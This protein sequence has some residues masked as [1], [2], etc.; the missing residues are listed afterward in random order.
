MRLFRTQYLRIIALALGA[1]FL[2]ACEETD[3]AVDGLDDY[4]P[5]E[6]GIEWTYTQSLVQAGVELIQAEELHWR[7]DGDTVIDNKSYTRI[8]DVTSGF[9]KKVVRKEGTKYYGRNHEMYGG[10]THEYVFLDTDIAE[11]DSWHYFKYDGAIKTEYVVKS[12]DATRNINGTAYQNVLELEVNYYDKI[13][14]NEYQLNSSITHA[15]AKGVGEICSNSSGFF[16]D[17]R[18]ELK[19]FKR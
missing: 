6:N 7:I 8:M 1:S 14:E 2:S 4:F 16:A 19:L 17:L 9:I 3:P 18:T 13:G 11:G 10:F 12:V 15:Y 5:L